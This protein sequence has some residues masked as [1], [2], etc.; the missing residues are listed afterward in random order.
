MRFT[1]NSWRS[2][3]R[4]RAKGHPDIWLFRWKTS[5]RGLWN[6]FSMKIPSEYEFQ[7]FKRN[8]ARLLRVSCAHSYPLLGPDFWK[9][10]FGV[11][12]LWPARPQK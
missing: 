12:S 3:L 6:R 5:M 8:H 10:F 1:L 4:R 2:A 9:G 7:R 11:W